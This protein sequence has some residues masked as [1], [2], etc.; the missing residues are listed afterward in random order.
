MSA[1]DSRSPS[2]TS[3]LKSAIGWPP[4][5]WIA[6]S[7]DTRVR[8]LG[9]WKMS[10]SDRPASGRPR[11]RPALA[12]SA[13]SRMAMISSVVRSAM[14]S[15]S[16]PASD[17]LIRPYGCTATPIARPARKAARRVSHAIPCA[18]WTSRSSSM[19]AWP[20][21]CS[22]RR[23]CGRCEP[24][25]PT[26]RIALVCPSTAADVAD[27]IPPVDMVVPLASASRQADRRASPLVDASWAP[28]RLRLPLHVGGSTGDGRVLRG[29]P[30]AQRCRRWD[31][32]C[33]SP[34]A[35]SPDGRR[36]RRETWL[37]LGR[38]RGRPPAAPQPG[39]RA[40]PR[41]PAPSRAGAARHRPGR[42][43]PARRH[44][45]GHWLRRGPHRAD[46]SRPRGIPS[47]GHTSPTSSRSVTAPGILLVGSAHDRHA[48]ERTKMDLRAVGDRSRR[49]DRPRDPRRGDCPLRPPGRERHAAAPAGRRDGD[50]D[51][52]AVRPDRRRP[53]RRIRPRR[54][55]CV[56]ALAPPR[57]ED[58]IASVA[59]MDQIRVEDVLAGIEATL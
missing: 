17:G 36:T 31:R 59:S 46:R 15:R 49:R 42:R 10:A 9:R 47:A 8:L 4:R 32:S 13:R 41:G 3:G 56:Q 37:R 1:A 22:R 44:R 34:V 23:C 53:R 51:R 2:W 27:G 54:T 55:G 18:A 28:S 58:G 25:Y 48:A 21:H 6:T 50:S 14:L 11:S 7:K 20:R 19:A 5:R 30:A 39:V 12:A 29:R 57:Y 45:P 33:C 43:P 26:A 40:R 38:G 52:R 35:S 16:R 24:G